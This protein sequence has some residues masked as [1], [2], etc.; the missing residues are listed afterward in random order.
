MMFVIALVVVFGLVSER[1]PSSNAKEGTHIITF[2]LG[3]LLMGESCIKN[4]NNSSSKVF[5]R[6]SFS[7]V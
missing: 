1:R 6:N 3:D 7:S 4:T 2:Q 5:R